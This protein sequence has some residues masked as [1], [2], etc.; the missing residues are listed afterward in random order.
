VESTGLIENYDRKTQEAFA[1]LT[2]GRAREAFALHKEPAAVRDRYGRYKWG[3]CVLLARRLVEAGGRRGPRQL[4]PRGGGGG[5]DEPRDNPMWDTHAQNADRLQDTLCPQF[6]V[7]FTALIDDLEKRGLLAETL[8]VAIGE[9]GR[10]PKINRDGGRDHW[11][12]VFSFV[13]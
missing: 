8:V 2:S 5:G 9:F 7:T 12:H 11:G 3:Q 10:T 4:A 1:L 13:M 6:D